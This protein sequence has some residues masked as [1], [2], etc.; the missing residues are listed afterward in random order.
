MLQTNSLANQIMN[1]LPRAV[2][3]K[4]LEVVVHRIL[5]RIIL[6]QHPPSAA[7]SRYVK[8]RVEHLPHVDGAWPASWLGGGNQTRDRQPLFIRQIA[9]VYGF[10]AYRSMGKNSSSFRRRV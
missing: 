5:G 9:G 4:R 1:A 8:Q 6:G 3:T 7:R 2:L 10:H